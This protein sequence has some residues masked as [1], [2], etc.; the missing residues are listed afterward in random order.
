[1]QKM[2]SKRKARNMNPNRLRVVL[3]ATGL[4]LTLTL[5]AVAD[6]PAT[7]DGGFDLAWSEPMNQETFWES[8]FGAGWECTKFENHSGSIPSSYEAAVVKSGSD[9]VRVYTDPPAQVLGPPNPN[10][11]HPNRRHPAPFSWVMKCDYTQTTTTQ[12]EGDT[13]TTQG[14]TTT[15]ADTTTTPT[16]IL[17][18][19]TTTTI[20]EP[21]TTQSPT[22]TS[23]GG[24][25]STT[26]APTVTVPIGSSIPGTTPTASPNE[27]DTNTSDE[28][29]F[30]GPEHLLP[31]GLV[32]TGLVGG[33][34]RLIR[35]RWGR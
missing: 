9:F 13:T 10:V 22:T 14:E 15:S 35:G 23:L 12:P 2:L 6:H 32:A 11:Q 16:T 1:M 20:E 8:Y 33:G 7:S 30:T 26:S 34:W 4:L 18:S 29:P 27:A 31:L 19:T 3:V 21:T 25:S 5:T 28:L 24:V 17:S